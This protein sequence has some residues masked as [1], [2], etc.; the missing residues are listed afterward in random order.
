M[1][2]KT[3][4]YLGHSAYVDGLPALREFLSF[5]RDEKYAF[6]LALNEA[7]LNAAKY[8]VDGPKDANIRVEFRI[9]DYDLVVK[10]SSRTKTCDMFAY[11]EKL[12]NIAARPEFVGADWQ[13]YVGDTEASQGFWYMLRGVE[14]LY[15]EHQG[16]S[17]RLCTR[18]PFRQDFVT[19]KMSDLLLRFYVEKDGVLLL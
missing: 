9:T 7:V 12:R 2:F 5:L 3:F 13:E 14:Y 19:E 18:V 10:V 15:M 1:Q 6:E 17:V 11:R 16:Q 8:A 4:E